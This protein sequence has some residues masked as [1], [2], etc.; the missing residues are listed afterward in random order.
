[1]S[2][3]FFKFR[4]D[5]CHRLTLIQTWWAL[6]KENVLREN[7]GAYAK[8][9]T[10][11]FPLIM[12]VSLVSTEDALTPIPGK[13]THKQSCTFPLQ[14]YCFSRY[15]SIQLILLNTVLL[16][17]LLLFLTTYRTIQ[18]TNILLLFNKSQKGSQ[19]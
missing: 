17:L 9:Q 8:Y 1:M 12:V 19:S 4:G 10:T 6:W 3:P 14:R 7:T 2:V 11:C 13:V 16:L 15:I 18:H 5:A